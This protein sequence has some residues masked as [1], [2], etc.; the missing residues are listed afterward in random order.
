MRRA[1]RLTQGHC[2]GHGLWQ[3]HATAHDEREQ[4]TWSR[5][6]PD[7]FVDWQARALNDDASAS[8]FNQRSREVWLDKRS[9]GLWEHA[10]TWRLHVGDRE[11]TRTRGTELLARE[12]VGE[13]LRHEEVARSWV[14]RVVHDARSHVLVDAKE[15]SNAG[16]HQGRAQ[17]PDVWQHRRWS[18]SVR[19]RCRSGREAAD[20]DAL[21]RRVVFVR[22]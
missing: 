4:V 21:E 1:S 9:K 13:P 17:A 14:V 12:E 20:L 6:V 16:V 18:W 7:P 11:P 2:A 22:H 5:R 3:Q 19:S 10:R 15:Q 8:V